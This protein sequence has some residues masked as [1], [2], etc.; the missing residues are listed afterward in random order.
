MTT[1]AIIIW[2][3]SVLGSGSPIVA[4]LDNEQI[5]N[6]RTI[7]YHAQEYDIDADKFLLLSVCESSLRQKAVGDLG[8]ARGVLQFHAKTFK[9]YSELYAVPLA[10][11]NAND[12][13]FLAANI[14]SNGG[15]NNWYNCSKQEVL[16]MK[17][18][19]EKYF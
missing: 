17:Q 2:I 9:R 11:D 6:S 4:K 19:N 3:V 14:I 7:Y 18:Q 16:F 10:Y 12:Q 5:A 13:I 15:I 1:Y 8:K